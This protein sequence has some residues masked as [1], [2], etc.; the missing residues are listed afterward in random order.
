LN[1]AEEVWTTP[2][3]FAA[4]YDRVLTDPLRYHAYSPPHD[5]KQFTLR[6][7]VAADPQAKR[8][9]FQ[10]CN[11]SHALERRG[12]LAMVFDKTTFTKLNQ[13]GISIAANLSAVVADG[14]LEF[15]KPA[16]V[17]LFINLSLESYGEATTGEIQTILTN[18]EL[19]TGNID[20]ETIEKLCDKTTRRHFQKVLKDQIMK[21]EK[22]TG[23]KLAQ[24]AQ[25][26]ELDLEVK[27]RKGQR[28][29]V[30]PTEKP[31]L[32][33]LVQLLNQKIFRSAITDDYCET[34]SYRKLKK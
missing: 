3:D 32:K 6:A 16:T 12:M 19:F 4:P 21:H 31:R 8:L 23:E 13:P 25:E 26:A 7:L 22:M 27:G 30:I 24:L 17:S 5:A 10:V 15:V 9:L 11:Q 2:F 28:R 20:P 33:Q 14:T 1:D 18:T 29:I 34:N